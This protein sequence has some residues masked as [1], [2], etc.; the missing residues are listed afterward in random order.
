M[1]RFKLLPGWSSNP[2]KPGYFPYRLLTGSGLV[3]ATTA[4]IWTK[5]AEEP[6]G[7][8][9][10]RTSFSF[11]PPWAPCT[12]LSH[13]I[14]T[15]KS[16]M[17]A[18][19]TSSQRLVAPQSVPA[20]LVPSADDPVGL[21]AAEERPALSQS[22]ATK[23]MSHSWSFI[24]VVCGSTELANLLS[25]SW[26]VVTNYFRLT[27]HAVIITS[28]YLFITANALCPINVCSYRAFSNGSW[29]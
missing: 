15:A 22:C 13:G 8:E 4:C 23:L 21:S 29:F 5:E 16:T 27:L 11:Q 1:I 28:Q 18:P 12:G 26:F 2:T 14:T 19:F 6:H 10:G 9:L 20:L 7:K 24:S 25:A 3:T 17:S